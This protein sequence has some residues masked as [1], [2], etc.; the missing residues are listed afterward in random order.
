MRKRNLYKDIVHGAA[1]LLLAAVCF[2]VYKDYQKEHNLYRVTIQSGQELTGKDA[3]EL[4]NIT[5]LVRFEPVSSAA[6][7]LKMEGY[8]LETRLDGVDLETY[9]LDWKKTEGEVSLGNTA[10]LFLGEDVFQAFLDQHGFA[11][12]QGQIKKWKE[13]YGELSVELTDEAG[14]VAHGRIFGIIKSPGQMACMDQ[15]QMEEI[16]QASSK[17]M[18]GYMEVYGHKHMEQAR[19]ALE[20][21][22]FMVEE[23]E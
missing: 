23:W 14:R 13:N 12:N 4:Q 1:I 2:H 11:P 19:A 17:E 18:G 20:S 21:G 22:G 7:T 5:G 8:T 10:A 15:S 9:P 16:F 3:E 6:V